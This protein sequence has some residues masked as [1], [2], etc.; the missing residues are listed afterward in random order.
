M[1]ARAVLA[2]CALAALACG[3]SQLARLPAAPTVV[4]DLDC[5]ALFA[6][7]DRAIEATGVADGGTARIDGFPYLRV[8]RFHASFRDQAL[9][10]PQYAQ[11]VGRLAALDRSA[12]AVELANLPRWR[13]EELEARYGRVEA[14]LDA[15]RDTLTW[16]DVQAPQRAQVLR[17]RAVVAD[18]YAGAKR[19]VGLYWL[20]ALPF[21]AGVWNYQRTTAKVFGTPLEQLPVQGRLVAYAPS[22]VHPA[23]P[24]ELRT[25][26]ARAASN[27]LRIPEPDELDL[28]RLFQVY[29][30]RWVVDERGDADRIGRIVLGENGRAE[31]DTGVPVVYRRAAHTRVGDATL[32][33]LVYSVW[34]PAR[35]VTSRFDLLG[36]HLDSVVWRVTL[37]PDGAPLVY[38]SIHSCG[39]YHQFFPT[40]RAQLLP[41]PQPPKLDEAAFVPQPLAEV[42]VGAA[43]TLRL[44]SST[45]Y[46]QRVIVGGE[47]GGEA[48]AF[49]ADDGLRSLPRANG[50]H[51]SAFRPDG[52]VEG[53]QRGER[54]LFW[55][56]GI[57]EPGAMRQ[58]GR[59]ATAFVGRRHFD[60]A[61]LLER[62]FRLELE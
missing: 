59:H 7:F 13:R 16:I 40:A 33:Q 60:E 47:S 30:P 43:L 8:D 36:G 25:I 51:R 58:W 9:D 11:W 15:C 28:E 49:E 10:D 56:M 1:K 21:R 62:Y 42:P 61:R 4:N 31:V 22:E 39:C 6:Q 5:D 37:A 53:S 52:I 12:R 18:D 46:L 35:P 14:A 24:D 26:L 23:T 34:F 20:T 50:E 54:Y 32:L 41:L 38:D 3:C 44:E 55:P 45:H 57:S 17:E 29:A 48:Y 27:P 19:V 2:L